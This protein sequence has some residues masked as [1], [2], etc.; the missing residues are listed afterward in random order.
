MR[1]Q[2]IGKIDNTKPKRKLTKNWKSRQRKNG[3]QTSAPLSDC[4]IQGVIKFETIVINALPT[5]SDVQ[6]FTGRTYPYLDR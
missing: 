3:E 6:V 2:N 1:L 4:K 5:S